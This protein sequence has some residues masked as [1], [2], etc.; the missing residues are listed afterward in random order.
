MDVNTVINGQA[1]GEA[2]EI[3]LMR[4]PSHE[5]KGQAKLVILQVSNT[6]PEIQVSESSNGFCRKRVSCLPA[7]THVASGVTTP[8]SKSIMK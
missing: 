3:I 1:Q 5:A 2:P 7:F 6:N 4:T 8:Y